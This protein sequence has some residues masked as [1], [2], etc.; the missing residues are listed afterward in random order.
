M[1]FIKKKEIANPNIKVHLFNLAFT[2]GLFTGFFP[3]ASGTVGS[4]FALA[5]FLIPGFR[6]L[7]VLFPVIILSFFLGVFLSEKMIERYG[8]DPSVVV[9]D[10][11]VGMWIT[12]AVSGLYDF[13]LLSVVV[14]F[15]M[16]RLFDIV[17]F[18]PAAFFD[19]M[20]N[21]FGIMMDDVIA[22]LYGGA[23]TI[24][25]LVLLKNIFHYACL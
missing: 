19:N 23:A 24:L 7:Y 17:K 21:G 8:D 14:G 20:K 10:E 9:I 22:G 15:F 25:I 5:F 2:S 18:Y 11:F 3:V 1:R 13:C 6:N 12:V 4:A 16:F